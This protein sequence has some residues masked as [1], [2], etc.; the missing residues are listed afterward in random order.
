VK[1]ECYIDPII[2]KELDKV[3]KA[4]IKKDR[5]YVM[6]IDGEEGCGKS[7]LAMQIAAYLDPKFN[8]DCVVF[9]ADQFMK[10]IREIRKYACVVL[11]EAYNASNSRASLSQVNRAMLGVA[12]EMRQRNLF[13][14]M[15]IPSFF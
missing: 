6:V 10:T 3:K 5:D 4:V 8:L 12:T 11:D 13:T 15:V 1:T 9:N 14:I 2:A 7:V